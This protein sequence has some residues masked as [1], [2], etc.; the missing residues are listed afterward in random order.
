MDD[1]RP[2][3]Y[4]TPIEHSSE[5]SIV[6]SNADYI[7]INEYR[8]LQRA[9]ASSYAVSYDD[10]V[11]E[12]RQSSATTPLPHHHAVNGSPEIIFLFKSF[13]KDYC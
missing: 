8:I 13:T 7:L 6:S 3:N 1:S 5:A 9:S 2:R 11:L 4:T 10:D 12:Q